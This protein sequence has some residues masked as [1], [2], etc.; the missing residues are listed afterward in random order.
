MLEF[1]THGGLKTVKD[2]E[3]LYDVLDSLLLSKEKRQSMGKRAL[4]TIEKNKGVPYQLV[5]LLKSR[6]FDS[7]I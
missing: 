4:Q 2:S 3:D 5:E 1:E 6:I 7:S